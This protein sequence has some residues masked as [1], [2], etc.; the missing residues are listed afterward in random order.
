MRLKALVIGCTGQ[1]GSYMTKFLLE[2]GYEVVG[3]SR[4]NQK[5][6]S[7]HEKLGI[8]GR[9]L[10]KKINLLN[11]EEIKNLFLKE[12]PD[13]V[14]NFSAQSSVGSSFDFPIETQQS[15]SLITINIL[16]ACKKTNF[17]GS[18]FFSGS[19]EMYGE[20]LSAA[21][22]DSEINPQNPYAIAKV[23]SY[24]LVKLYRESYGL[25]VVTGILFP[26]ESPLRST[27]F[28][29]HKIIS[30]AANS[31]KDVN[32]RIKLGNLDIERDWGWA[33]EYMSAIHLMTNTKTL[34]DQIICTGKPTKLVD[35]IDKT[36]KLLDLNWKDHIKSDKSLFREKDIIRSY[37][38]PSQ[39]YNDLN[40]KAERDIEFI[41]QSLLNH[42]FNDS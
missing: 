18:I 9:F 26:H 31:L 30:A 39:I 33:E 15:I 24:F 17:I 19:S 6:I 14:Y 29:I 23:E 22:T 36:F 38:D 3:T 5:N 4:S 8:K 32:Y 21:K 25:R 2:K 11:F 20:T 1:D 10:I 35:F 37:G 28:V 42:K 13:E 40:W 27:K 16:E 41:I 34:K 7:N 12:K